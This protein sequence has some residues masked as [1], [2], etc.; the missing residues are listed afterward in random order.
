MSQKRL[1]E[2]ASLSAHALA[3]F[4]VGFA[5]TVLIVMD[6]V[7]AV[8]ATPAQ[9]AS[10]IAAVCIAIGVASLILGIR[11]RQP[12]IVAW[13]TPGAALLASSH[14]TS[15]FAE[16]T[17]A[18]LFAGL[19]MVIT[20]FAKPLANAISKLPSSIAGAMLA[21]V[22]LHYVIAV[23][24]A[25]VSAP[26]VVLPLAVVFFVLR[27][28]A[29]LYATPVIVALALGVAAATGA[30]GS[31]VEVSITHMQFVAPVLNWQTLISIGIPLYLVTMASQNLPGF[32]VL[33]SNSY[34]PPVQGSIFITGLGSMVASFFGA[35][36][37]NL[38]AITA[39]MAAGS[40][41][42]PD[43][44]QRWKVVIPYAV[45]YI[46]AGLAAATFVTVL[47]LLPA[48]LVATVAGLALLSPFLGG[49]V[50]MTKDTQDIEAAAVTFLVTG[51]GV[52]LFGVGAAFWGLLTGLLIWCFKQVWRAR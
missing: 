20:A 21:G 31:S 9:Q 16:A 4:I 44:Q 28:V 23:P 1:T 42:H 37:V 32:A 15:N 33:K 19:L 25:A 13:S 24:G 46:C 11:Y 2:W 50:A 35:H 39:A 48:A 26:L 51:S 22:L 49:I 29:P 12:I 47:G 41:V 52:T 40:D 18:F 34:E 38:A 43:P 5:S 27:H 17:A 3:I 8:G 30:F 10:A 7:R 6:A 45:V 36:A 14:A